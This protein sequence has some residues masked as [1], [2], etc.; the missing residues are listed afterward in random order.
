MP[1]RP[2]RTPRAA[3][4]F[5][6]DRASGAGFCVRLTDAPGAGRARP[7]GGGDCRGGG[8]ARAD[9]AGPEW[10][11]ERGEAAGPG[12]GAG[13]A[14]RSRGGPGCGRELGLL[15]PS[16]GERREA[17]QAIGRHAKRDSVVPARLLK[18]T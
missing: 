11:A 18:L 1:D 4:P 6:M 14:G 2:A 10:R 3:G 13:A 16:G 12:P 9:R 8:G 7:R 15:A 17:E 5:I